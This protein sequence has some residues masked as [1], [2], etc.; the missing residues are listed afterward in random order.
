MSANADG[1]SKSAPPGQPEEEQ[2]PLER[3]GRD[4]TEIAER[5]R[6]IR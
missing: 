2:S 3:F 6:S 4:L 5:A 1:G